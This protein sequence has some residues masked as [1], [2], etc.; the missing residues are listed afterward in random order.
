[1]AGPIFRQAGSSA[2][3][4]QRQQAVVRPGS[5]ADGAQA[6]SPPTL[7]R[8]AGRPACRQRNSLG[9]QAAAAIQ[10]RALALARVRRQLACGRST[11]PP[12]ELKYSRLNR[13]P[14][15]SSICSRASTR[16]RSCAADVISAATLDQQRLNLLTKEPRPPQ[17]A[18]W[19]D[20]I[21]QDWSLSPLDSMR[22]DRTPSGKARPAPASSIRHDARLSQL[23]LATPATR[24][25]ADVE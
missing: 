21:S 11:A 13:A 19:R 2:N 4:Q 5:A 9:H 7:G 1:M 8:V 16:S 22:G 20:G 6:P 23:V 18:G 17:P 12:L 15:V 24:R 3:D 14:A 10:A 25:S